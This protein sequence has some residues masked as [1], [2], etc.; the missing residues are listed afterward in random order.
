MRL[1]LDTHIFLWFI[2][3][4]KRLSAN[5]RDQVSHPHNEVYLS[6][7]SVWEA[8][9]KQQL[10][11]LPLPKPASIY[12]PLQRE[13]HGIVSLPLAET[14][15]ARLADLPLLHRDPFD[16]ILICQAIDAELTLMTR[17]EAIRAYPV[18]VF[19]VESLE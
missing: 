8:V 12:L 15:V 13:R 18:K 6:V 2:S 16:R 17:D 14:A 3:D 9:I 7:V 4:D 19:E 10:G 1:L 11:K 5:L